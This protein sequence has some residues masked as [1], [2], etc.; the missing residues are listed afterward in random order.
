MNEHTVVDIYPASFSLGTIKA[1][2]SFK[3][4]FSLL[5]IWHLYPVQLMRIFV[6]IVIRSR[7]A[8]RVG[9]LSSYRFYSVCFRNFCIT[10]F[11][12]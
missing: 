10:E 4:K 7:V 8:G 2:I 11:A 6:E 9:A 3:G 12:P 5:R 1:F